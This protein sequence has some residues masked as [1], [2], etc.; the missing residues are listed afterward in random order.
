MFSPT[1]LVDAASDAAR[2]RYRALVAPAVVPAPEIQPGVNLCIEDDVDVQNS[3]CKEFILQQCEHD[4]VVDAVRIFEK[5]AQF[6]GGKSGAFIFLV[7]D[8]DG[9]ATGVVGLKCILKFYAGA[10]VMAGVPSQERPFREAIALCRMSG[11]S[12]F[13]CLY[14]VG[15]METPTQWFGKEEDIPV[16]Q[17]GLFVVMSQAKGKSLL[18]LDIRRVQPDHIVGIALKLLLILEYARRRMGS[19]FLHFDFHADNIFVDLDTT[20]LMTLQLVKGHGQIRVEA[21]RVEV[22]DF[23]LVRGSDVLGKPFDTMIPEQWGKF[24]GATPVPERTIEF[25]MRLLGVKKGMMLISAV[26]GKERTM[27]FVLKLF[28]VSR[29]IQLV[30]AITGPAGATSLDIKNWNIIISSLL[31][32]CD[33]HKDN[34]CHKIGMHVKEC[35][36]ART[37]LVNNV[38][39]FP[40]ASPIITAFS[41]SPEGRLNAKYYKNIMS[42]LAQ[43]PAAQLSKARLAVTLKKLSALASAFGAVAHDDIEQFQD[44]VFN[45]GTPIYGMYPTPNTTEIRLDF[46]GGDGVNNLYVRVFEIMDIKYSGMSIFLGFDALIPYA[47]VVFA[48]ELEFALILNKHTV[49]IIMQRNIAGVR[50]R[51]ETPIPMYRIASTDFGH[52]SSLSFAPYTIFVHSV[53]IGMPTGA[54]STVLISLNLGHHTS[55]LLELLP[56]LVRSVAHGVVPGSKLTVRP[57]QESDNMGPVTGY[58][59]LFK[60]DIPAGDA[61]PC[62]KWLL[63]LQTKGAT[64]EDLTVC[65]KTLCLSVLP[66]I[67]NVLGNNDK[68]FKDICGIM[69]VQQLRPAGVAGHIP[70]WD[71]SGY[72]D[73]RLVHRMP[74][75]GVNIQSAAIDVDWTKLRDQLFVAM[76]GGFGYV[77]QPYVENIDVLKKRVRAYAEANDLGVFDLLFILT[78]FSRM[79]ASQWAQLPEFTRDSRT[80]GNRLVSFQE[81]TVGEALADMPK[82]ARSAISDPLVYDPS[83]SSFVRTQQS[84]ATARAVYD[85][86]AE[87][88]V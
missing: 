77:L 20:D 36:D 56:G 86:D 23:D 67:W 46:K 9:H 74:V 52:F 60:L 35:Y 68:L 84:G 28:G 51:N 5:V 27:A 87:F 21:P 39:L 31:A 19:N 76:A 8:V 61:H 25:V 26:A 69:S 1:V 88:S 12:G 33:K 11:V 10:Y 63:G 50:G 40:D 44:K 81:P 59:Y 4:D 22:I 75:D 34:A 53:R 14:W 82:S 13:P 80:I 7:N 15:C 58:M 83:Y 3:K 62:Q 71:V 38:A 64:V 49:S 32:Y 41:K 48:N 2:R 16:D 85:G 47:R 70:P 24:V 29:G 55:N 37:C 73:V 6:G 54:E 42:A 78:I 30:H 65:R 18:G 79:D 17:V 45:Y 57:V 43:N 66:L 72:P